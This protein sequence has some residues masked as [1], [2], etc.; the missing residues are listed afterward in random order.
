M[1]AACGADDSEGALREQGEAGQSLLCAL[2]MGT[3]PA[4][5]LCLTFS[6]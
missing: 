6:V 1:P 3:G 5:G 4:P 2:T